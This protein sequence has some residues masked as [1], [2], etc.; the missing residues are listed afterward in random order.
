MCIRDS[1]FD[2]LAF[3]H[4]INFAGRLE[5]DSP[6][7]TLGDLL[8]EKMQIVE[9]NEKDIKDTLIMLREHEIQESEKESV[10]AR[11]I[12][13]LLSDDWGFYHTATT[14]LDKV[15]SH[16]DKFTSLSDEDRQDIRS[17]VDILLGA[18]EK[19]PKSMKWQMRAKIGTR[20]IWYTKVEAFKH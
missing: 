16:L 4:T 6:T 15:K 8:L 3:C 12:A 20:K 1:F 14:N 10:N 5:L 9:I 7:I 2:K 17:K 13:K 19:E 11:Y 18:I